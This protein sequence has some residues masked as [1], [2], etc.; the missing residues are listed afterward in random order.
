MYV[1]GRIY[2]INPDCLEIWKTL[3]KLN[4]WLVIQANNIKINQNE[5]Q[6][7]YIKCIKNDDNSGFEGIFIG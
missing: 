3:G 6:K 7:K 4:I 2:A 5:F 1:D